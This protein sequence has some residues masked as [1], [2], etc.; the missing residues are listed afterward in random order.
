LLLSANPSTALSSKSIYSI[1][2][3]QVN[4]PGRFS[5]PRR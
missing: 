4:W 2:H 3:S 5:G 1:F